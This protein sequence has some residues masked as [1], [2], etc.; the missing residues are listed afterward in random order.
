MPVDAMPIRHCHRQA[1][2]ICAWPLR[3]AGA[4]LR[5]ADQ[6]HTR[7]RHIGTWYIRCH[8]M[9]PLIVTRLAATLSLMHVLCELAVLPFGCRSPQT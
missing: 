1:A 2:A 7:K 5:A 8:P 3:T 6:H 4:A 9:R